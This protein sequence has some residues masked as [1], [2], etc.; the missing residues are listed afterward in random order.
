MDTKLAPTTQQY[1]A[2]LTLRDNGVVSI[3]FP[4]EQDVKSAVELLIRG[5]NSNEKI[6]YRPG[7]DNTIQIFSEKFANG[8][9]PCGW[10]ALSHVPT[11]YDVRS[12]H[13]TRLQTEKAVA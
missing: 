8:L 4:R 10:M 5:S 7:P 12:L 9:K 13:E 2:E 6:E 1:R 11:G 3:T